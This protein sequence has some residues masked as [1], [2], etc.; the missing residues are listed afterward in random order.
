M[1]F[2]KLIFPC[3]NIFF[4]HRP[5]PPPSKSS[6]M[7]LPLIINQYIYLSIN[8]R[9][10]RYPALWLSFAIKFPL[11]VLQKYSVSLTTWNVTT[12][13]S[14]RHAFSLTNIAQFLHPLLSGHL[15]RSRRCPFNRG[16]FHCILFT[17]IHQCF[18]IDVVVQTATNGKT[19]KDTAETEASIQNRVFTLTYK[20]LVF[21]FMMMFMMLM[22]MSIKTVNFLSDLLVIRNHQIS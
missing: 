21:M 22:F 5:P 14:N 15:G 16:F 10:D 8:W 6:L 4:V 11:K 9:L 1:N 17:S 2:L 12:V 18:L 19:M 3:A 7:V 13:Q 20:S